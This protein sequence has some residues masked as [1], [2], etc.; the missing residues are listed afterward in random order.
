MASTIDLTP[1][2]VNIKFQKGSTLDPIFFYLGPKPDYAQIDLSVDYTAR[3]K[4]KETIS[5]ASTLSGFDLTTQNGGLLIVLADATLH[6]G[7]V[8]TNRYGIRM[9]VPASVTAAITWTS[10]VFDIELVQTSTGRVV[11]LISGTLKP[12]DE[13]TS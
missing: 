7:S 4:A 3:M 11:P 10:A 9:N 6:N 2:Q 1:P 13:V 5:S 8:L 12:I